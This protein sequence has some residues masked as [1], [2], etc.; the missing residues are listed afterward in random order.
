MNDTYLASSASTTLTVQE[1]PIAGPLGSSPLPTEYWTHPIYG[2]GTDWWTISSNWLG[3][4]SPVLSGYT[5]NRLYVPDGVGPLTSHVMWTR[6]L[7]FGGVVG[8]NPYVEGGTNPAGAVQGVSY[9]EGSSYEPRFVNPLIIS[10]CLYYTEVRSFTGPSSGPTDCVDLRTGQVRWSRW[11]VPPLSF[12]YIYNLWNGDQ[13]GTFPPIL[14]TSNFARAFDGYTGD[15]L[16]NVTNVPTGTAVAGPTGEQIRYVLSNAGT[17]ANPQW[18]LAQ[19]NSS[20]L[21]Q[22]DVNPYTGGGSFNPSVINASNL[23]VISNIPQNPNTPG[24]GTIPTPTGGT[25]FLVPYGSTITVNANI[26]INSTT[27]GGERGGYAVSGPGIA[28]YDWNI[29]VPWLNTMPRAPIYD[30]ITD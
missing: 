7:E 22:Y 23:V 12:G 11:D 21:W 3:Q 17:P 2:E 20:K 26:P 27:I 25:T 18:Y 13:H 15:Q 28:T 10:G 24:T 5:S 29:S 9:F 1:E 30:T 8:G 4:G 16:F 6:E 19:W 14:F